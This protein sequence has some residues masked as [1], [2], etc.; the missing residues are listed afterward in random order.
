MSLELY[1][2]TES[3]SNDI[4]RR[5]LCGGDGEEESLIADRCAI[6]DHDIGDGDVDEGVVD[7]KGG[8]VD[9][10]GTRER[11]VYEGLYRTHSKTL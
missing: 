3:E 7:V 9:E 8:N 5:R 6:C 1:L 4:W 2:E 10:C 11:G